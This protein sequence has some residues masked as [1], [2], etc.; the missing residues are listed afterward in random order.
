[1]ALPV[2]EDD[3]QC[4]GGR[5]LRVVCWCMATNQPACIVFLAVQAPLQYVCMD[6]QLDAHT[7]QPYAAESS[8]AGT[9]RSYSSLHHAILN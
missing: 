3:V 4:M 9:C 8:Y 5:A 2:G 7:M 1:M 6:P